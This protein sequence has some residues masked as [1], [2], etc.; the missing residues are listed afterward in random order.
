M[1]IKMKF[2]IL[3]IA[4]KRFLFMS[5]FFFLDENGGNLGI[6]KNEM[7]TSREGASEGGNVRNQ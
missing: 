5:R 2:K 1:M 7:K 4:E 6:D 3:K